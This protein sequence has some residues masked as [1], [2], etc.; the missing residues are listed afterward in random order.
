MV[1]SF[2]P[3]LLGQREYGFP[4]AEMWLG[5]YKTFS[6]KILVDGQCVYFCNFLENHQELLGN[7]NE[8]FFYL[9]FS[10]FKDLYQFKYILQ[11]ILI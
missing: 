6:S 2:I 9:R 3:F 1:T 10:Q 11:K 5:A 7:E 4:K 8:L